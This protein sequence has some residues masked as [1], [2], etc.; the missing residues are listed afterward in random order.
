K[1]ELPSLVERLQELTA[2][3]GLR[4]LAYPRLLAATLLSDWVFTQNP[5]S[6][7]QVIDLIIKDSG[8]RLLLASSRRG[9]GN[10]SRSGTPSELTLPPKCGRDE[11]FEHCFAILHGTI[12]RDYAAQV[13]ELLRGNSDS[14]PELAAQWISHCRQE[15]TNRL[16]WLEYG[17]RLGVLQTIPL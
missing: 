6:V 9:P 8:L 1:G 11:L 7:Q 12:Q 13:L 15:V 3:E 16:E 2:E 10:R 14:V 5:K 17:L 4:G